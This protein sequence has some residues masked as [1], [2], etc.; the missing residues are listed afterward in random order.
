MKEYTDN[1]MLLIFASGIC[2]GV[3]LMFLFYTY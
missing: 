2:L 3:V 1:D